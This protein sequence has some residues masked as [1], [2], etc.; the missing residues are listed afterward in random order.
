MV[1]TRL[2]KFGVAMLFVFCVTLRAQSIESLMNQGQEL[3]SRGAYSQAVSA[4]RK[5]VSRETDN[6]EAQ[7][8]LAFAY[9]Q[10]GR[11][12]NAVDEFKKALRYHSQNSEVWSNLAI[13]YENLGKGDLAIGALYKAV[14]YNPQNITARM[15]LAAMYGNVNRFKDA[16]VQYKKVVAID[17]TNEDALTNLSKC[18]ISVGQFS[19]AKVFLQQVIAANPNSGDAHW[20]LGNIAWNKE[21]N[22]D[23]GIKEYRLAIAVQPSGTAFYESLASALEA[24][25]E[26]GEAVE[27]LKKS[28]VFTD[29]ALRKEKTQARIDRIETGDTKKGNTTDGSDTPKLTTKSQINDLKS[30]LRTKEVRQSETIETAPVDVMGDINDL[31]TEDTEPFDLKGEAKK[32]AAQ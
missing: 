25:G 14:Q 18:L 29:D 22:V 16:I 1:I 10:W 20:E 11:N 23:M 30:E 7:F 2:L 6:F 15:N 4:F 32:R 9:L 24:K 19:E 26:K 12:S 21:K 27:V 5:I 17:N 31:E 13:A 8:N 3:L 28:L